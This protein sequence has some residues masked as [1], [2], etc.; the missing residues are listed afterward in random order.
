MKKDVDVKMSV[1]VRRSARRFSLALMAMIFIMS[2]V[3][4]A[5]ITADNWRPSQQPNLQQQFDNAVDLPMA[6]V[7][8]GPEAVWIGPEWWVPNPD[9]QSWDL[10]MFYYPAYMGPHEV[11]IY[12][13]GSEELIKR[14]F[15]RGHMFHLQPQW[16]IDGQLY[17]KTGNTLWTYDPAENELI[18]LG[19]PTGDNV[20]RTAWA[21]HGDKFYG[22]GSVA[23]GGNEVFAPFMF[24]P[25]TLETEFFE[26]FELETPLRAWI[27][28]LFRVEGDWMYFAFG[29]TPWQL[30]GYNMR[31]EEVKHLAQSRRIQGDHR[32]MYLH[33][34]SGSRNRELAGYDG[35]L[36]VINDPAE[37]GRDSVS[38]WLKDGELIERGDED[39][40]PWDPRPE[41]DERQQQQQTEPP[42]PEIVRVRPDFEGVVRVWHRMPGEGDWDNIEFEVTRY[43]QA[44]RRIATLPDGR[45]F[46]L[47]EAYG[48]AIMFNPATG[49]RTPLGDT[50]SVYSMTE[51]AGKIYMSGYHS[52]R[53]WEFD[54]DQP[55]TRGITAGDE[56]PA[57][58][59]EADMKIDDD[60]V[61]PRQVAVLRDYSK[62]HM[63]IGGTVGAAD[64]RLY[65]GGPITR[66]GSGGGLGWYDTNTGEAGGLTAPFTAYQIFW[67]GTAMDGRYVLISTKPTQDD[68][69]PDYTPEQGALFVFDTEEG[70]II[71]KIVSPE[72]GRDPGPIAEAAP[73]LVIGHTAANDGSGLLFGL[74]V[75]K[76]EILWTKPVPV[77]QVTSLSEIRRHRYAYQR[78]PDGHIWAMMGRVLV[79]IRPEDAHVEVLGRIG[80]GDVGQLTFSG[81]NVYIAGS[82]Y[83]RRIDLP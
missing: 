48:Q 68:E 21:R 76:E 66:I 67:M 43:P 1:Y 74:D 26:Q 57:D 4:S 38:Y 19:K 13:F 58:D 42:K 40:P 16:M 32:T 12:D 59:D 34:L 60:D 79:R 83:L 73:G 52:S 36:V 6:N 49:E 8:A 27:Y 65:V 50:M 10:V 61:N 75:E 2:A 53:V 41:A 45:I 14:E 30:I 22:I 17:V 46:M 55:W 18:N 28:N 51:W 77:R 5:Q 37:E 81:G 70:E 31:T 54:P 35:F 20:A 80:Q 82:D 39:T 24:D 62:V 72:L 47:G 29:H 63:P 44:V 9:G 15:P 78:G 11:F 3:A 69:D 71:H 64:G 7:A 25:K 33:P 56:P 23:G